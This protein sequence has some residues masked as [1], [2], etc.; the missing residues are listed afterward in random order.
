MNGGILSLQTQKRPADK[1]E[2][3]QRFCIF[4]ENSA[5]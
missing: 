5:L 3:I 4:A 2:L 1:S